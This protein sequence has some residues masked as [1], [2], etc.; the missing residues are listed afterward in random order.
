MTVA[1]IGRA[2]HQD[3][4][5]LCADRRSGQTKSCITTVPGSERSRWECL[6]CSLVLLIHRIAVSYPILHLEVAR[7]RL[8]PLD[9][10]RID[11]FLL[12]QRY[13]HPLRMYGVIF[14]GEFFS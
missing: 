13:H 11:V 12:V 3:A 4:H 8:G 1:G 7:V 10:D 5:K 6:P 2:G 9:T 14:F